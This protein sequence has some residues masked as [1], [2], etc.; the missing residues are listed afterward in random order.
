M[1]EDRERTGTLDHPCGMGGFVQVQGKD[2]V[3]RKLSKDIMKLSLV[4]DEL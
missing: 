1:S 2:C 3:D 4:L